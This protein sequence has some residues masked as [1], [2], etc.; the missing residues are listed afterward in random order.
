MVEGLK[1]EW[2][3]LAL[4]VSNNQE[5][6]ENLWNEIEKQYR[7][8]MRHYHNLAH[9]EHMLSLANSI[10]S[11]IM[12]YQNLLFAI[13]YHDII[14]KPTRNNNEERSADLAQK[15]LKLLNIDEKSLKMIQ[16]LIVSTKKHEIILNENEDNAYLLDI[17][18]SILGSDWDS[19]KNYIQ[20]IRKE[21][22]IYPDFMYK[23]GRKKVL[24]HFLERETL[25]F[26][27][28]FQD[29]FETQARKNLTQE[30]KML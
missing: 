22:A 8:K 27:K 23:K 28:V 20:N 7:L 29:K 18:L 9:I 30:I 6:I 3:Q 11:K 14:Y 24:Q 1:K 17:D 21:Y 26:T 16:N 12:N 10:E 15:R 19:Y 13:W 4:K 25:Y 2:F 5:I